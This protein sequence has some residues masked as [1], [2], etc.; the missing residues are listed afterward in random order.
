MVIELRIVL[1][2]LEEEQNKRRWR[3][4]YVS[5]VITDK[6][7]TTSLIEALDGA[8]IKLEEMTGRL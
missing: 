1:E 8:V 6:S 7:P 2:V 5:D 4:A 3:K